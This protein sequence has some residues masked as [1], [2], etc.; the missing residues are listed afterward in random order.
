M[1]CGESDV[2]QSDIEPTLKHTTDHHERHLHWIAM[3]YMTLQRLK[4]W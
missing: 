4:H 1:D 3:R 2:T